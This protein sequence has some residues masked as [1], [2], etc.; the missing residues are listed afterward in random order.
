METILCERDL[1]AIGNLSHTRPLSGN[2]SGHPQDYNLT[3]ETIQFFCLCLQ[4]SLDSSIKDLAFLE[5]F[6]FIC[7]PGRKYNF[8]F[9]DSSVILELSRNTDLLETWRDFSFVGAE[10]WYSME[11]KHAKLQLGKLKVNIFP[12]LSRTRG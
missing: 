4:L 6:K 9:L 5:D 7:C 3:E 12:V 1:Q 8:S 11:K 10:W 2:F